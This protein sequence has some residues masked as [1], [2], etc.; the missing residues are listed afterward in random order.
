MT[1]RY[2]TETR[3]YYRV[4]LDTKT[5]HTVAHAHVV[6]DDFAYSKMANVADRLNRQDK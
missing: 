2:V 5:G 1:E 6:A 3:G 4:V